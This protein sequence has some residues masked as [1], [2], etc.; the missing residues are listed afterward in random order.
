MNKTLNLIFGICSLLGLIATLVTLNTTLHQIDSISDQAEVYKNLALIYKTLGISIVALIVIFLIQ[1][2]L[3]NANVSKLHRDLGG[4]P[5]KNEQLAELVNHY[6]RINISTT[7]SIHNIAH[8][9]RYIYI[10][11]RDIVIDLRKP[12]GNTTENDC[13]RICNEFDKFIL[14]LLSNITSTFD[15]ITEDGCATC[16]KLVKNNKVKTLYRDPGS[17]RVRKNSDYTQQGKIFIYN[18]VDNFA[19]NLIADENSKETFFACDELSEH[20]GYHNRNHEWNKLYDATIVVPVQ[21]NLSGNKRKKK[22][23]LLAFLCKRRHFVLH[24]IRKGLLNM[25]NGCLPM[26]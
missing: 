3:F 8:S 21:A 19:F 1:S 6:I 7:S 26:S 22:M 15:V 23:H 2:F 17:Y 13:I 14:S 18:V 12:D 4:L 9:Y 16:I 10:L 24:V 5:L 20:D 25:A 11:L